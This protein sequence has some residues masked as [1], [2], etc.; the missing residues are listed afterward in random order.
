FPMLGDELFEVMQQLNRMVCCGVLVED[1][2]AGRVAPGFGGLA[3]MTYQ[4]T[5]HDL[6]QLLRGL[7]L[8]AEIMFA[9][10][11]RRIY[12]PIAGAPPLRSPDDIPRIFERPLDPRDIETVSVHPMGTCRM[13]RDPRRS[14][15]NAFGEAHDVGGLF[16]AD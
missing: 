13:G 8:L 3:R 15:V 11:A 9:S 6:A 12:T 7:G 16:V 2:T 5:R 10:G 4:M 1:T 14:V